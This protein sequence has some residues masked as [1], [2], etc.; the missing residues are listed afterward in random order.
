M[1]CTVLFLF[2]CIPINVAIL[3][4]Y[5]KTQQS[6]NQLQGI[7]IGQLSS[8]SAAAKA[9]ADLIERRLLLFAVF[10]FFGHVLIALHQ[11]SQMKDWIP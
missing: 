4:A 1:I 3:L 2:F 11:V 9:K 10:T 6:T 7:T 8:V 5:R